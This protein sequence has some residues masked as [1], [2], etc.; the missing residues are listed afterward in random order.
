MASWLGG[1]EA[2][3]L[4]PQKNWAVGKLSENLFVAGKFL[5]VSAKFGAEE[6]QFGEIYGQNFKF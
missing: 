2:I 5:Y 3:A 4:P 6:P 1:W